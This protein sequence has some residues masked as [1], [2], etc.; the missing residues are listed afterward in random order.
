MKRNIFFINGLILVLSLA[1]CFFIAFFVLSLFDF[2]R[3]QAATG[4]K[5]PPLIYNSKIEG[6]TATS[7]VITWLTDE[8]SDSMVNYGLN[9][10][11][12]IARDPFYDKKGHQIVIDELM[13][14]T[15]YYFRMISTDQDG[16]QTISSDYT[17]TTTGNPKKEEATSDTQGQFPGPS[18]QQ[19]TSPGASD[20]QGTA[21]GPSDQQGTSPGPS[22]TEGQFSLPATTEPLTQ[23]VIDVLQKINQIKSEQVLEIIQEQIQQQAEVQTDKLEI[24]LDRIDVETGV[25]YATIRWKT[26]K[27][28]NSVVSLIEEGEYNSLLEDPYR[29]SEG[30]FN[31]AVLEHEVSVTGLSPATIYHFQVSSE[32]ALGQKS[33]SADNVFVTKSVLPEIYN[34]SIAKIEED[35]ATITF[36]TNIPCSSLVEYTNLDNGD[37]RM[38]G[39]SAY[40][41]IHNVRLSDLKYDTYY[42][43]VITVESEHGE[44]TKS[45]PITFLTIKDEI[46]PTVSKVKNEST[47][48]PGAD[49]KVQTIVSWETDEL[50]ICQFFYH[51]GL[52]APDKVE[53]LPIEKDYTQKHTQVT[54]NLLPST[55][56]KFWV[57]CYD[58]VENKARSSDFIILTPSRE[59]SIIDIILK[60]FEG[61]FGWVKKMGK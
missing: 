52:I 53:E 7:A 28:A 6:I 24:I 39:S 21:P 18:D 22:Q 58:D 32:T 4:D 57:V 47:L 50:A 51:Q 10:N 8:E 19:G 30:Q 38:E 43:A 41:T 34:I 46:P 45:A 9:R 14:A 1:I 29:W 23:D 54:T 55:V 25:D 15:T 27:E 26:N 49:N 5:I 33:I 31:D 44:K 11:Y 37:T 61:T 40:T 3:A 13:P 12:G 17:F 48:Y 59:Q 36:T 60:N 20:Q 35:A 2:N 16:N 42:S 56:Y